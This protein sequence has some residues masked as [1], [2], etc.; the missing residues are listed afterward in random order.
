MLS[1]TERERLKNR[2]SKDMDSQIKASNDSR[3]RRKLAAWLKEDLDDVHLILDKLPEDQLKRVFRDVDVYGL[4]G[5]AS[6]IMLVREFWPVIGDLKHPEEWK[7]HEWT[8]VSSRGKQISRD[9]YRPAENIDIKRAAVL[10]GI[11][12]IINTLYEES[13]A[14]NPVGAAM[15]LQT[16]L[17]D[18]VLKDRVTDDEKKAIDRV[19]EALKSK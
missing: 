12:G 19:M 11:I 3:V 1:P 17:S 7:V 13:G 4:L 15:M 6:L 16:L 9:K 2:D 8:P 14:K 18:P 10:F 5:L